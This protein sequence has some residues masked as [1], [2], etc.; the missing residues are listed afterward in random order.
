M[1]QK[2]PGPRCTPHVRARLDSAHRRHTSAQALF[3]AN[4]GITRN[5]QR[6]D[7]AKTNL[8]AR[9]AEYDATPGG[10]TELRNQLGTEDD[11]G[12]REKLQHRLETGKALRE[13]Q[14]RATSDS[15]DDLKDNGHDR[16]RDTDPD[17]GAARSILAPVGMDSDL[18]E[19]ERLAIEQKWHDLAIDLAKFHGF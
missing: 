9:S 17:T 8:D 2:Y 5:R 12:K 3:D 13:Q 19:A 15:A 18:P 6:L 16:E 10:Q 1:C 7:A 4:P 14:I 11:P